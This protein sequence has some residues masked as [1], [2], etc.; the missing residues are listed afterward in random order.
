MLYQKS[1]VTFNEDSLQVTPLL[2][3]KLGVFG[4]RRSI[5]A[6]CRAVIDALHEQQAAPWCSPSSVVKYVYGRTGERSLVMVYIQNAFTKTMTSAKVLERDSS[7]HTV[8]FM[9]DILGVMAKRGGG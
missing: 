2:L 3:C 1:L 5:P 9:H 6:L 8:E 7:L 4:A